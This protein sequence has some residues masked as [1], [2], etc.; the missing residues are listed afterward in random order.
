M[1]KVCMLF[2]SLFV[3]VLF[4][5]CGEVLEKEQK[6]VCTSTENDDGMSSEQIISMTYKNDKLNHMTMEVN[7]KI[8]DATAKE[9][10]GH[11]KESMAEDNEE[12]NKDGV[13]LTVSYDDDNYEY[14]TVLDIDVLN[15]SEEALQEQGFE[16]LK[17]DNSTI[18]ENKKLAEE[19]GSVCEIK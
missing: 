3:M 2:L 9:Y 5:G 7:T 8:T 11:F 13:S 17:E 16:D 6:L 12:F 18:E 14:K 15:A 1:K 10:W 19:N 4:T